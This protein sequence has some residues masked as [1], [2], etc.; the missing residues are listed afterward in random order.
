GGRLP[1]GALRQGKV[2]PQPFDTGNATL[3]LD[4]IPELLAD[5]LY[6]G[7]GGR[8][9]VPYARE[10]EQIGWKLRAPRMENEGSAPSKGYAEKAGFEDD[11]ISRRSLIGL[12]LR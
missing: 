8:F 3:V 1:C 10:A 7:R 6:L 11:I 4:R 2:P 5:G 12:R 9:A